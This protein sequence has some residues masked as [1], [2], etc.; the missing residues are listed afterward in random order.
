MNQVQCGNLICPSSKHEANNVNYFLAV[1][2]E[3]CDSSASTGKNTKLVTH[4]LPLVRTP[5]LLNTHSQSGAQG[6]K[7]RLCCCQCCCW[8]HCRRATIKEAA[9]WCVQGVQCQNAT[10]DCQTCQRRRCERSSK[11]FP[12]LNQSAIQVRVKTHT[13][14]G[15]IIRV[16]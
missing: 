8:P 5:N 16:E 1:L 4:P 2:F 12:L 15:I 7:R 14:I 13:K 10:D 11:P 3:N 9:W 6:V